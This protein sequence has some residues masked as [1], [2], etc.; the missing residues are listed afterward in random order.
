MKIDR[1]REWPA[2][3]IL[4]L[5]VLPAGALMEI[6]AGGGPWSWV[7]RSYLVLAILL[8][9]VH[10]MVVHLPGLRASRR[11][12]EFERLCADRQQAMNEVL[13]HLRTGD[14]VAAEEPLRRL[15]EPLESSA[16]D[17][18]SALSGLVQQ[19]QKV[20][21]EVAASAGSVEETSAQLASGSSEQAASV[22]QITATM[23][24]LARTAQ[25]IAGNAAG[26]AELAS[27]A[28]EAG[29]IGAAAVESAVAGVETIREHMVTIETRA[30]TLDSRAREIYRVLD[31]ITEIAQATHILSLNAAIEASAAGEHGERFG[32]VAR[33]VRR[34]A[35]RSRESV[36]S[37]RS[38]L[39][40]FAG[41][42]RS[43]VIA[44]E[45]GSRVTSQVL[46]GSRSTAE[47]I[48]H[49]SSA[50][51]D[52]A[53]TARET[54][55]ATEEQRA[56][57]AEVVLTVKE[58]S[59]VIQRMADGLEHYTGVAHK[60]NNLA[61]S[62]QLLS[63]SFR[64]A[65]VHSL[66]HQAM[67]MARAIS[68]VVRNPE[69]LEGSLREAFDRFPYLELA[70]LTDPA[71]GMLAFAVNRELVGSVDNEA[72]VKVGQVYSDRPWFKAVGADNPCAVTPLYESIL[73][74]DHCFS[75]VAV[76]R[77][78]HD[79]QLGVLGIDVNVR[80]WARI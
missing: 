62:I 73:T 7:V 56:A 39:D 2:L 47:T 57:S 43:V 4:L 15:P 32:V 30:D 49:L 6:T 66:K 14:L 59:E 55:L 54:S 20:S 78:Q 63:Q 61:L 48:E 37:V 53:R 13:L 71:G 16:E 35:E 23:E 34:L 46:A 10:V 29:R 79:K 27:R 1:P 19:I 28:E 24:E 33:E 22:V 50:L 17:A 45:E 69:A 12:Q 18:V 26:Q 8:V 60:L 5:A 51:A 42:I 9:V 77:D 31:L 44:T 40:E 72:G 64:I 52:T 41:A 3:V 65:S 68:S 70:Y 25:Q 11:L 75:V 67:E 21:V 38:L 36:D 76:V 74:G 80:N 58:E